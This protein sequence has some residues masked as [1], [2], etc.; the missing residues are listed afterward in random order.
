MCN[1][2][3][4]LQP[5][6]DIPSHFLLRDVV[7]VQRT[8]LFRDRCQGRPRSVEPAGP[9]EDADEEDDEVGAGDDEDV[10]DLARAEGLVDVVAWGY[11]DEG[12]ED[13]DEDGEGCGVEDAEERDITQPA[14]FRMHGGDDRGGIAPDVY[15]VI[16][17]G[18]Q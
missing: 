8:P 11:E 6:P 18:G 7:P 1:E 13:E 5:F 17:V 9:D 2:R 15:L 4:S 12:G 3:A 16:D 14:D 10:V